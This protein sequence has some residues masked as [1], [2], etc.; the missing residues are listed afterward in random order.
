MYDQIMIRIVGDSDGGGSKRKMKGGGI[1]SRKGAISMRRT[2]MSLLAT[3]EAERMY[4]CLL[5]SGGSDFSDRE[6]C[7]Y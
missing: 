6:G 7:E 5:S 1:Y 2:S 4:S 3:A